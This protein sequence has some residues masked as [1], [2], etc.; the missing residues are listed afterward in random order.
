M[1]L[2]PFFRT[3]AFLAC[4]AVVLAITPA[5]H[6]ASV[7]LLPNGGNLLDARVG[8]GPAAHPVLLFANT[9][10][11][12]FAQKVGEPLSL[13]RIV[14]SPDGKGEVEQIVA[15]SDPLPEGVKAVLYLLTPAPQGSPAPWRL[16]PI[17]EDESA[18]R[19]GAVRILNFSPLTIAVRIG[20]EAAQPIVISPRDHAIVQ[21]VN[22][23]TDV[24][25]EVAGQSNEGWVPV[26]G[27]NYGFSPSERSI[28]LVTPGVIGP[29]GESSGL[30][31]ATL[32][33]E[34]IK[35]P[36]PVSFSNG[37]PSA[38]PRG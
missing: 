5:G 18:L 11:P 20:G 30:L 27:Q 25:I 14:P 23:Q 28:L 16:I 38:S 9:I 22:E 37:R 6:A 15:Q 8:S 36:P 4:I 34:R 1:K 12:V 26:I 29:T 24:R 33:R 2:K 10:S 19:K 31:N 7:R 21:R 17:F 13:T 35:D 32:I 3:L